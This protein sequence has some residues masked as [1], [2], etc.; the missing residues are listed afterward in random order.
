MC[1]CTLVVHLLKCYNAIILQ[2]HCDTSLI[3]NFLDEIAGLEES[4][5][6]EFVSPG[7]VEA[8]INS[9]QSPWEEL[10]SIPLQ[11]TTRITQDSAEKA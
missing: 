2:E 5:I 1:N 6:L 4:W 3:L 11:I 9:I 10:F 8:V 7:A